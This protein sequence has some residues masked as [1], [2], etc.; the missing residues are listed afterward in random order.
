MTTTR[1]KQYRPRTTDRYIG[2]DNVQVPYARL[3]D[4][5][6]ACRLTF[7]FWCWEGPEFSHNRGEM[8]LVLRMDGYSWPSIRDAIKA[9][10]HSTAMCVARAA[11]SRLTQEE[12]DSRPKEEKNPQPMERVCA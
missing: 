11:K 5:M 4:A 2:E 1:A 7:D 9:P 6:E 10:A 12:I 8:A 3:K